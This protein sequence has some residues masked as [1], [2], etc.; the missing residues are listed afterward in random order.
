MLRPL[1]A[2]LDAN[3]A[4]VAAAA[5]KGITAAAATAPF[6]LGGGWGRPAAP[7]AAPAAGAPVTATAWLEHKHTDV[8]S[9]ALAHQHAKLAKFLQVGG[10]PPETR[11]YVRRRVAE[12]AQ[13]Q[14]VSGYSW[15]G[16]GAQWAASLPTDAELLIHTLATYLDVLLPPINAAPAAAAAAAPGTTLGLGG[17]AKPAPL[18][19]GGGAPLMGGGGLFGAAP[20]GGALG[21]PL[22]GA[23]GAAAGGAAGGKTSVFWRGSERCPGGHVSFVRSARCF[24]RSLGEVF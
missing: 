13:G 4:K 14:C 3:E 12:L 18:M 8:A 2:L 6:A 24:I 7:A 9:Q 10:Y 20:L 15:D 5:A 11:G 21:A 1:A 16:G 19:G 22:G 17:L 23:L